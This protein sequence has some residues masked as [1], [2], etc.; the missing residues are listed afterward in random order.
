MTILTT[1]WPKGLFGGSK[2]NAVSV[3]TRAEARSDSPWTD[4]TDPERETR[5]V[6]RDSPNFVWPFESVIIAWIELGGSHGS[7]LLR[8]LRTFPGSETA[9]KHMVGESGQVQI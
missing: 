4:N 8:R 9:S 6:L 7:V 2:L 3:K 5:K 1:R